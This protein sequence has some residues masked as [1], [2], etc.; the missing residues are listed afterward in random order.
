MNDLTKGEIHHQLVYYMFPVLLTQLLQQV[1][2]MADTAIVGHFAEADALAAVG[3]GSLL[4]SVM[5]NFFVGMATGIS[6]ILASAYGG[7][8]YRK[9]GENL[10]LILW[11]SMIIGTAFTA[12]GLLGI[13]VLL[14]CVGTPESI[15]PLCKTYLGICFLGMVAQTVYN[16]GNAAFRAA[17]DTRTPLYILAFTVLLNVVLDVLMVA[18]MHQGVAGAAWATVC[19]QYLSMV[20]ML[21]GL[22]RMPK[23]LRFNLMPQKVHVEDLKQILITGIPS[24]MQALLMSISSLIIQ[25][26][27]NQFGESAIAGMTVYA[28]IEGFLYLPLFAMGIAITGFIGQNAGAGKWQ[29]VK[30]G[31]RIGMVIALGIGIGFS[32]VLI[33]LS[34]QAAGLFTA[35]E[36]VI[37]NAVEAVQWTFPFYCLY[38][39]NQIYIGCVRGLGRTIKVMLITLV[40][41]CFFRVLWC[42]LVLPLYFSMRTIYLSYDLSFM[43]MLVLLIPVW[44]KSLLQSQ[45]AFENK[46]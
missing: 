5:V 44:R 42:I 39:V 15:E 27:I 21:V 37:A 20:L 7:Q 9:F 4:T 11:V 32:T 36:A 35:D 41:Y 1:Y 17:G 6:A 14:E 12:V 45:R 25:T 2:G 29:R 3:I 31:K 40:G 22:R 16:A 34:R 23:K 43:V 30:D 24:G 33:L 19:S 26:S 28:K 13:H 18:G 38:A 46:Y 10:S 8:N